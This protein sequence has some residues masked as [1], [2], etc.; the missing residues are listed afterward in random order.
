MVDF[1]QMDTPARMWNKQI[2]VHNEALEQ[3]LGPKDS[4][5]IVFN[6]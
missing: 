5:K 6:V 4:A 2:D 1:S 3:H